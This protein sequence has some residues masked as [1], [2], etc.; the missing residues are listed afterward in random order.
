MTKVVN[1]ST[2]EMA[3]RTGLSNALGYAFPDKNTVVLHK[4]LKGKARK[5][6]LQHEMD[7]IS[8][9]EEGPFLGALAG[10]AGGVLSYMG[11]KKQA[12]AMSS[13]AQ[14]LTTELPVYTGA[15]A[16]GT[17][18]GLGVA[19]SGQVPYTW[20]QLLGQNPIAL[21]QPT[22]PQLGGIRP[23]PTSVTTP[24]EAARAANPNWDTMSSE[25]R[26]RAAGEAFRA[27][28]GGSSGLM[29][30]V[31]RGG[32]AQP[33]RPG[34][35][36]GTGSSNINDLANQFGIDIGQLEPSRYGL[37]N[38]AQQAIARAGEQGGQLP[39]NVQGAAGGLAGVMGGPGDPNAALLQAQLGQLYGQTGATQAQMVQAGSPLTNILQQASGMGGLGAIAEA[40]MSGE[41]ARQRQLDL[42]RQAAAP[43]EQRQLQSFRENLFATGRGATTGGAQLAEA[44]ARGLG[45]ADVQR[46]LAASQEG[47]AAQSQ[48]LSRAQGLTGLYGTTT[49]LEENLL[50]GAFG[51]FAQTQQLLGGLGA[52]QFQRG[53]G[54]NELAYSR[55]QQNLQTQ[56]GLAQFAPQLQALQLAPAISALQAQAGLQTQALEPFQNA[57][58]LAQAQANARIGAGSNVAAITSNANF[59]APYQAGANLLLGIGERLGQSGGNTLTNAFSQFSSPSP[60]S[61][62]I[63]QQT[64]SNPFNLNFGV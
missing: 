19:P 14:Q 51:R 64:P 22:A 48:A 63:L 24:V 55:A 53:L 56:M 31:F 27:S 34:S 6:V 20:Q 41:Q 21:T 29:S 46:Q 3:R 7:H 59:G 47:R 44:F 37:V 8:K 5:A 28:G 33:L 61:P 43:E 17:S 35:Y 11:S 4:A 58:A 15:G 1:V 52:T 9:G 30:G 49:G 12:D 50:Q 36:T 39:A 13:A 45:Q 32:G 62:S 18:A 23:V 54:L 26:L 16:G 2:K 60:T 42:L 10:I 40:G 38:L 25:Q 57:L